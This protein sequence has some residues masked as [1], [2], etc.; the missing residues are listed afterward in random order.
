MLKHIVSVLG[1]AIDHTPLLPLTVELFATTVVTNWPSVPVIFSP[2]S[3]VLYVAYENVDPTPGTIGAVGVGSTGSEQDA[4]NRAVAKNRTRDFMINRFL[5]ERCFAAKIGFGLLS[6]HFEQGARREEGEK[7]LPV[8]LHIPCLSR[9]Y[10]I[11]G[12]ADVVF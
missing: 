2:R 8:P 9:H 1:P 6:K 5:L 4:R 3:F 7:V 12:N 11:K 10:D